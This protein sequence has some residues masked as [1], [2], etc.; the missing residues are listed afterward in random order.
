MGRSVLLPMI[1]PKHA[2]GAPGSWR[3]ETGG[4]AYDRH[5]YD[6]DD[7]LHIRACAASNRTDDHLGQVARSL[8]RDLCPVHRAVCDE[9]AVSF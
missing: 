3:L 9:R 4:Y 7:R 1:V 2:E 5:A 8:T 6:Y